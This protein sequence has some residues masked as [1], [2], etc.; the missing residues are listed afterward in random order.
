MKLKSMIRSL[1]R[2]GEPNLRNIKKNLF[3]RGMRKGRK[4]L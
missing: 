3:W 1:W 4:N 2:R